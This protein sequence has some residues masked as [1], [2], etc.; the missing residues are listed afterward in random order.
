MRLLLIEDEKKLSDVIK[1]GLLEHGFAIDQAYDG[2]EGRY[3]AETESYDLIILDLTIPKIDGLEVCK[4]LREKKISVP[5]LILT[6]RARTED[7]V[8]GLNSGADDYLAKPFE[9]SELWAR[10]Q[11][12][13]RR[14]SGSTQTVIRIN[15]LTLDPVKRE[16][17]RGGKKIS[18][19]PKEFSIL[20]FLA[21]HRDEPVTRTQIIEHTW[22]Y[23]FDSLSNVVDVFI[24][25]LR[26]KIG[27]NLIKTIHG[28]GYMLLSENH[29]E[30]SAA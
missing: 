4:N 16:V 2:E 13:L 20:E 25:T 27:K 9:F 14:S 1:K 5:I 28:V 3:L 10:I 17:F 21:R 18:L 22:D 6:A 12:L 30:I 19:T 11:A 29:Y 7:K 24:A 23:N 26:K 8:M 15:N